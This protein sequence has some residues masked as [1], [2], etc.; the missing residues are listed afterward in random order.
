MRWRTV[1]LPAARSDAAGPLDRAPLAAIAYIVVGQSRHK[2]DRASPFDCD[3]DPRVGTA[4]VAI[5]IDDEDLGL[6]LLAIR[7]SL[8]RPQ[9]TRPLFFSLIDYPM[10]VAMRGSATMRRRCP[11]LE[12]CASNLAGDAGESVTANRVACRRRTLLSQLPLLARACN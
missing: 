10:T 11:S 5:A 4:D 12:G 6:A 2:G 7:C 3:S 9:R 1:P 8:D